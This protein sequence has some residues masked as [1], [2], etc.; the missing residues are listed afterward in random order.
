MERFKAKRIS[1][2]ELAKND[3]VKFMYNF[4]KY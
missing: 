3:G 4:Y 1:G 2:R